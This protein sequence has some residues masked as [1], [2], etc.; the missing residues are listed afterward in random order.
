M[1]SLKLGSSNQVAHWLSI[2]QRCKK[3]RD[4]VPSGY[5]AKWLSEVWSYH[6][7]TGR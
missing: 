7:D 2:L 4:G 1:V 6:G 5:A 3:P